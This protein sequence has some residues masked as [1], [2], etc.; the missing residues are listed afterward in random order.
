MDLTERE[1]NILE[2]AIFHL[3]NCLLSHGYMFAP[4]TVELM[5]NDD[6]EDMP[7]IEEIWALREKVL[8]QCV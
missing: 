8:G 4:L 6:R 3:G 5:T 2:A 7:Q 1:R